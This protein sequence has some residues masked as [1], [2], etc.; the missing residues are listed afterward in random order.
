MSVDGGTSGAGT[1]SLLTDGTTIEIRP[2]R[3]DDFEAVRDMHA[4]MSPENL[5]MRFFGVSRVAA[6]QEARRVCHEPA[7]D[8]AALLA[9]LDDVEPLPAAEGGHTTTS[10]WPP[11]SPVA[12]QATVFIFPDLDT[13]NTTYKAVQRSAQ[14]VSIGPMLQGLAKP[15]ND[16]SRG[17]LAAG[18]ATRLDVTLSGSGLA[19]IDQLTASEVNAVVTGSG[20]IRVTAP[21]EP[22]RCGPRQRRDRLQRQPRQVTSS[23]TG[24]GTVT[25]G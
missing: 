4:A 7:P 11:G 6:E 18:T 16:L 13:G 12:G 25:R 2:A 8:H 3:P 15:V 1:Y 5:Y 21:R 19:Q 17:A 10:P 22:G 9:I 20:L 14:V 24:S 23:V